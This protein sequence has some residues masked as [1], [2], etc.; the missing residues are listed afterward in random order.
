MAKEQRRFSSIP[1]TIEVVESSILADLRAK[2]RLLL[3][4]EFPSIYRTA[5]AGVH[6]SLRFND[7]KAQVLWSCTRDHSWIEST[8]GR[9]RRKNC[10]ICTFQVLV[11]GVN[12]LQTLHP[13]LANELDVEKSG[14]AAGELL[15][16]GSKYLWWI[17]P[18]GHSYST[19]LARRIGGLG[20]SYCSNFKLL[21]G[22]NDFESH[23]PERAKEFNPALNGGIRADEIF[24]S[25]NSEFWWT[26]RLGHDYRAAPNW[27]N[28][29]PSKDACYYCS[30][31]LLLEGFNDAATRLPARLMQEFD[32][33]KNADPKQTI[34][35]KHTV[36]WWKCDRGHS[37][38]SSVA[39]RLTA[40]ASGCSRC[41]SLPTSGV[42][43]L[44]SL[45]P[46][47]ASM[48][49][50]GQKIPLS[51]LRWTSTRSIEWLCTMGHSFTESPSKLVR[52]NG[53][54]KQ[55]AGP[56]F[57]SSLEKSV[58]HFLSSLP[59]LEEW[60]ITVNSFRIIPP[61]QIDIF[62]PHL[63]AAIEVN[64]DYY[65]DRKLYEQDIRSGT[66]ISREAKK[67]ALCESL[68][69][70]VFHLW[71]EDWKS[72]RFAVER[73]LKRFLVDSSWMYLSDQISETRFFREVSSSQ[74]KA[75]ATSVS[76]MEEP[77]HE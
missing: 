70:N 4:K 30:D 12:D 59:E 49:V 2:G 63:N 1:L 45:Y 67:T 28:L 38:K 52:Q 60:H 46:Q 10:P 27:I 56:S 32:L 40:S 3:S 23:C 39:T 53:I 61:L 72:K 20:C 65:H 31:R 6:D 36:L 54:C 18:K 69:I 73:E 22:F 68:G 8:L 64:G 13:D 7:S 37:W 15:G 57:R 58:F 75:E 41:N 35:R 76:A 42:D 25:S 47:I 5:L 16:H 55:C 77:T 26:C 74:D 51:E 24:K 50:E 11:P 71:E 48:Y 19:K 33:E 43:D 66:N 17:C 44:E 29:D 21:R 34:L 14:M 9:L 62:I